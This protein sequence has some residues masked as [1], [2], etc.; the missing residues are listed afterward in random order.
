M[1]EGSVRHRRFLNDI[2]DARYACLMSFIPVCISMYLR[3]SCLPICTSMP[4]KCD[5]KVMPSSHKP[6]ANVL[7]TRINGI[8]FWWVILLRTSCA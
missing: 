5:K 3:T 4:G 7:C 1:E 8:L 2:M 6:L